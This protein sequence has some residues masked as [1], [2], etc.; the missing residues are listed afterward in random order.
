MESGD[1]KES[2]GFRKHTLKYFG[3]KMYHVCNLLQN[4]S[5]EKSMEVCT[6]HIHSQRDREREGKR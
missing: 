4:G 5:K 1:T 2:P 3:F 6:H